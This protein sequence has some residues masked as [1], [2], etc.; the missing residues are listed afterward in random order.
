MKIGVL[1]IFYYP[2]EVAYKNVE[3]YCSYF[4]SVIVYDNTPGIGV[5]DVARLNDYKIHYVKNMTNNGMSLALEYGFNY[6]QSIQMD[7]LLTM[8]QDSEFPIAEIE[9]MIDHI[10]EM[11][12]DAVAIWGCNYRKILIDKNDGSIKYTKSRYKKGRDTIVN[13]C[14]TS[15]SFMN[16][17]LLREVLPFE[18]LFIGMVDND[19]G[20]SF[21]SKGYTVKIVGDVILSQRVGE[22]VENGF[23]NRV[24]HKVILSDKRYYYMARNSKYLIK[25]YSD[26]NQ[27]N[28]VAELRKI[29]IRLVVNLYLCEKDRLKKIKSWEKGNREQCPPF[30][31]IG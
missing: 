21:V 23:L 18:N 12:D 29:R 9:K 28:I 16:V 11:N 30:N 2:D 24:L 20:Y 17:K 26:L 15:G 3:R 8:D 31:N 19:I 4:D 27:N 10:E 5:V 7:Y 14:M 22:S 13:C 1:V 25:K 6:A